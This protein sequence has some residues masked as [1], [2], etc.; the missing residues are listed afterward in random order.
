MA[1]ENKPLDVIT[2]AD[3]QDLITSG[4]AEGKLYEYKENLPGRTDDNKKEFLADVSSFANTAGGHIIYGV[5]EVGGLPTGFPGLQELVD[6]D[7]EKLRLENIIRNGIEPRIASV[8]IG[9]V[10]LANGPVLVIRIPRSWT[11]PHVVKHAGTFRFYARNSAG[12]YPLDVYELRTAFLAANTA[13]ENARSFRIDRVAK[14]VSGDTPTSMPESAKFILHLIPLDAFRAGVNYS[15]SGFL[16]VHNNNSPMSELISLAHL[17]QRRFNFDGALAYQ[18]DEQ[19]LQVFRNGIVEFV[20][21]RLLG[22]LSDD[23]ERLPGIAS[24]A[25]EKTFLQLMPHLF[26]IQKWFEIEPPIFVMLSVVGVKGFI[27]HVD[28]TYRLERG[29]ERIDRNELLIPEIVMESFDIECDKIMR[30]IFDAI[31]NAAGWSG[32]MNYDPN[33]KWTGT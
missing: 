15:S 31:W 16:D 26:G 20:T 2:E 25:Y 8:N 27:M 5:T 11:A 23:R 4:V 14:I 24:V 12:K 6:A 17:Y 28:R 10:R 1:L 30:P 18:T 29:P 13:I 19:Y 9:V 22:E 21:R 33:G 7:A 3:F 32:S